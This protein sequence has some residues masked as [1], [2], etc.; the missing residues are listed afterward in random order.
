MR[1]LFGEAGVVDHPRPDGR[2]SLELGQRVIARHGQHLTRLPRRV[3]HEVM[4]RLVRPTHVA[5]VQLGRHGLDTLAFPRQQQP[6]EIRLQRRATIRMP[7]C[8]GE[9]IDKAVKS[10]AVHLTR[11][12]TSADSSS[13]SMARVYDTVVLVLLG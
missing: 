5:G 8:L 12:H 10:R 7:H 3:R 2:V 6:G 1:A 11:R 4:Q 13:G 9:T